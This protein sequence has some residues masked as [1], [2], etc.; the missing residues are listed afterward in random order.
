MIPYEGEEV[1]LYW[2]NY[3]QYYI[4]TGDNFKNYVFNNQ[5]TSPD[6]FTQVEFRIL[7]AQV[8]LNNNKEEKGRLFVPTEDPFEWIADE[9]KLLVKFNYR[10][11]TA[12]EKKQ[13]GDKQSVKTENKGI[14]Q[15]LAAMVGKIAAK[16]ADPELLVFLSTT[17]P[18][19]KKEAIPIFQHHLE[20]YTTVNN[21]DYFIHKDLK[22]FLRRE[23]DFFLKNEVLSIQF[24]DADWKEQEVQEAIKNNVLKAAAIRDIAFLVIDFMSELEEFQK[25]LFERKNLLLKIITV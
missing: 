21:F 15:K 24:L 1:K 13:W 16:I 23:L 5:S 22:A 12:E 8:T 2:A 14:N 4:K 17:K 3:D 6:T 25:R 18:N 10:V 7:D 11:P 20:R 9:R 19:S